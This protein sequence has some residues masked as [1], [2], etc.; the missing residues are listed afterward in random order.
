MTAAN[1]SP[2]P[3]I[4]ANF[5]MNFLPRDLILGTG[6]AVFPHPLELSRPKKKWVDRLH[7]VGNIREPA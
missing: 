4:P 2:L 3:I 5:L 7:Y 1:V 6:W